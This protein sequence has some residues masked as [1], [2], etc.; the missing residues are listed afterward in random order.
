MPPSE[1]ITIS[2]FHLRLHITANTEQIPR[3]NS[4]LCVAESSCVRLYAVADPMRSGEGID[5]IGPEL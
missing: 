1:D 4:L 2:S 5:G 3:I